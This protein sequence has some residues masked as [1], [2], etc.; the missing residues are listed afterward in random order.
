MFS[1]GSRSVARSVITRPGYALKLIMQFRSNCNVMQVVDHILCLRHFWHRNTVAQSS[2]SENQKLSFQGTPTGSGSF[3]DSLHSVYYPGNALTAT[4]W[5]TT[6]VTATCSIHHECETIPFYIAAS[7]VRA[8]N[9]F[10]LQRL[11]QYP[12][13]SVHYGT[14]MLLLV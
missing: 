5:S 3:G 4:E 14:G 2:H 6:G 1:Q 8:G 9:L 11:W 13:E 12:M 10:M 7:T